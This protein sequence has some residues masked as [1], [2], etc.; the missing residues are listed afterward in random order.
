MPVY[1]ITNLFLPTHPLHHSFTHMPHYTTQPPV[2][3]KPISS[4]I[5]TDHL[6]PVAAFEYFHGRIY[7]NNLSAYGE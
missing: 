4:D 1:I 6:A 2:A 3:S 7:D 5:A